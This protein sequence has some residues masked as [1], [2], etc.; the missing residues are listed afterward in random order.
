MGFAFVSVAAVSTGLA[1]EQSPIIVKPSRGVKMGI[2][3]IPG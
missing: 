2:Q 1:D 3:V